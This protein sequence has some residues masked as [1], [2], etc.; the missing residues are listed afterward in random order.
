MPEETLTEIAVA[1]P[2]TAVRWAW[3]LTAKYSERARAIIFKR[4]YA[5]FKGAKEMENI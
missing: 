5:P 4:G 1:F 2:E 3:G